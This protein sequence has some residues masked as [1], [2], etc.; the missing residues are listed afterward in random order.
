MNETL[1][2]LSQEL[3]QMC[4]NAVDLPSKS[5]YANARNLIQS[6]AMSTDASP[7]RAEAESALNL[8]RTIP[9]QFMTYGEETDYCHA[10]D[11]EHIPGGSRHR[12]GC[13]V[14]RIL[15]Q[16]QALREALESTNP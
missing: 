12:E 6:A 2:E 10:C 14:N 5:S 4:R 9:Q 16:V 1:Y 7:L 11:L 3:D 15:A 8:L 13:L